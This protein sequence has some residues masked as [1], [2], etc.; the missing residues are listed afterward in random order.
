MIQDAIL[1]NLEDIFKKQSK[2]LIIKNYQVVDRFEELN[3]GVVEP[4]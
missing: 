1:V 3:E 4:F 2:I